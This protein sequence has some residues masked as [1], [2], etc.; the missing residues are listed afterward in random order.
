MNIGIICEYNPFHNG[1][2]YHINKV[3]EMYKDCNIIL[4][5]SSSFLQ[6]GDASLID[7]WDKTSIALEYG[8]DIVIELPF[9]FSTQSADTFARGAIQILKN[10]NVDAIVF[11]SEINDIEILSKIA[12]VQNEDSFNI[13]VQKYMSDGVNY[14]TAISRTI[15]DMLNIKIDTPN[16]LLAVSYIKEI[17]RQNT[18]IKPICIKRT[19][20][21]HDK[22]LNDTIT[23]ATSIRNALRNNVDIKQYVPEICYNYLQKELYY[24]EEYFD[25]LKYKI[26]SASD[27]SIYQTV[28]EGIGS[29]IK[30]MILN[31]NSL[32]ELIE[33]VKTKRYTH[34]KIKRMLI[35]IL[36]GFTKKQALKMKNSEYIRILGFN[37]NGRIYLNKVKKTS[38]LPIITGYSNIKSDILDLELKVSQ[39]YYLVSKEKNKNYLMELEYKHKPIIK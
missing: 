12:N 37:E 15:K 16:D 24:T 9:V 27:L 32:D 34:N 30:K 14:P 5:M 20:D 2:L 38:K 39:I 17:N 4:V 29:R 6:R 11:G 13:S 33:N 18:N 3:K 8:V 28:D 10:M 1:H 31:S 7:K 19:N 35:H 36:C 26:L 25:L 22:K 21:F 23:S